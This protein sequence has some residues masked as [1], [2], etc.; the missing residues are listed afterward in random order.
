MKIIFFKNPR[1]DIFIF[2]F[3]NKSNKYG[4]CHPIIDNKCSFY[5]QKQSPQSL[6]NYD[7]IFPIK[8][9]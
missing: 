2:D 1:I 6:L 4:L 9:T 8:N 3:N 5:Q 7:D